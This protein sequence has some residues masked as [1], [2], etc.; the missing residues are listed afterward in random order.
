MPTT[1][2]I[3]PRLVKGG[4]V[5]LDPD[6][7]MVQRVLPLQYN[8]DTVT[9]TVQVQG[10]GE[11]G[12]ERSEALR[13]TG[14]AIETW[15]VEAEIDATDLLA[16]GDAT[17]EVLGVHPWLA[18]LEL[19]V[20]PSSS[21][22]QSALAEARAGVFEIAPAQAPLTLF[23]W[24]SQR[25]LP[26]R[27]TELSITEEAFDPDLNPIRARIS[28]GLRVLS[29]D[30]LGHDHR[31]GGLFMAH[32]RHKEGLAQRQASAALDVLGI[33]QLP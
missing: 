8:A 23:V 25:V 18:A 13:L 11:Q 9:R 20:H 29:V 28:L 1:P 32:L 14:P 15:Q 33:G 17:A 24:S 26:V 5:T 2:P 4:L 16:D 19:L 31:G 21:Q 22:L 30:D 3:A 7:G 12:G 6:T 27:I 10:A